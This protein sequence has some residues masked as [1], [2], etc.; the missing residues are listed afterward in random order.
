METRIQFIEDGLNKCLNCIFYRRKQCG[1][2]FDVGKIPT[3]SEDHWMMASDEEREERT[4]LCL[5]HKCERAYID[6]LPFGDEEY[7][8]PVGVKKRR[9]FLAKCKTILTRIP[10]NAAFWVEYGSEISDAIYDLIAQL[11]FDALEEGNDLLPDIQIVGLEYDREKMLYPR[12]TEGLVKHYVGQLEKAKYG[13][14]SD[15]AK[16]V[17]RLIE[18]QRSLDAALLPAGENKKKPRKEW[19]SLDELATFIDKVKAATANGRVDESASWPYIDGENK[20]QFTIELQNLSK[21]DD[22]VYGRAILYV[23]DR[24]SV[25]YNKNHSLFVDLEQ[26]DPLWSICSQLDNLLVSYIAAAYLHSVYRSPDFCHMTLLRK[27][28]TEIKGL[29]YW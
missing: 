24:L 18:V 6:E 23:W 9:R 3:W 10:D 13:I 8:A 28:N 11:D 4:A 19:Q 14:S 27:L 16:A 29:N 21:N 26:S 20:E 1:A 2:Y 5:E 7:K 17:G 22:E 12:Y 25:L 15:Q